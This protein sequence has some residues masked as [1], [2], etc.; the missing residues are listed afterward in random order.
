MKFFFALSFSGMCFLNLM[1]QSLTDF[2][3]K[4][5]IYGRK[6]GLALTMIMLNPKTAVNGK[7]IINL[8]NGGWYTM[9]DWIPG[10]TKSAVVYLQR[11]YTVFLVMPAGRPMY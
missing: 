4:E 1:G 7:A 8:V 6:D 3:N 11:G 10:Y 9:E 5:L 2:S